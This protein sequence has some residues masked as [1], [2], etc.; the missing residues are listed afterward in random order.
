MYNKG[1]LFIAVINTCS[2]LLMGYDKA[3]AKSKGQR[4]SEKT[5]LSV[6]FFG[7]AFGSL[8]GM[9]V[10][11]HK[12]KHLQFKYGVPLLVVL[13]IFGYYLVLRQGLQ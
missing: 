1:V 12:T 4:V 2:F 9:K 10:F 7:G 8:F 5:L 6:A 11:R 13:N 3:K